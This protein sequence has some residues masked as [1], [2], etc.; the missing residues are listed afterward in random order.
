VHVPWLQTSLAVHESPS[1]HGAVLK[2]CVH[3]AVA[4]L[5]RS[6]VQTLSSSQLI[7]APGWHV[8]PPHVSPTVHALPSSQAAVLEGCW[9]P[10]VALQTSSVHPLSS[11]Q[12]RGAPGIQDP[13][14]QLSE[15]VQTFPSLQALPLGLTGLEQTPVPVLQTPGSWH[16]SLAVQTTG[17]APLQV[18]DWQVSV[19]VHALP[20]LHDV[21]SA[22]GGLEHTPVAALQTPTS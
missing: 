15:S 7:A 19:C 3:S 17:L 11:L 8:P 22:L 9:Q 1:S 4:G 5:H 20:S 2:G 6:V 16:V 13:P 21:P 10:S 12:S 14:K 18:P